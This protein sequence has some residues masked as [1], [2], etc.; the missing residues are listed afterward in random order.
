MG[1]IYVG[2]TITFDF[3]WS[4]AQHFSYMTVKLSEGRF[5]FVLAY[6]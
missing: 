1:Q 2:L 4:L 3:Y 6:N 5:L